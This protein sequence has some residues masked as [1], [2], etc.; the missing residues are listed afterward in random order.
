[1]RGERIAR[2]FAAAVG[3]DI[4]P[5]LGDDA[6]IELLER[7]GRGIA[8][9]GERFLAGRDDGLVHP[10]ELGR[11]HVDF[12]ADFEHVG[13]REIAMRRGASAESRGSCG[14]SA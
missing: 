12:A 8:R 2:D 9:V 11:R 5:P 6:R 10:L 7:A 14:H 1:M 13:D 3:D 4:E